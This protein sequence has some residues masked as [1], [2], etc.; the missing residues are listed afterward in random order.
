MPSVGGSG[1]K[2][3][4]TGLWSSGNLFR[5]VTNHAALSGSLMDESGFGQCQENV[6]YLT[7]LCQL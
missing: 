6:T 3:A 4:A 5:G 2:H 7:A 1:V